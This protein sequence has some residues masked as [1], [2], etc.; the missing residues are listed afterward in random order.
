MTILLLSG[1]VFIILLWMIM[2]LNYDNGGFETDESLEQNRKPKIKITLFIG[3][4]SILYTIFCIIL[5]HFIL[6]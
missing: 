3:V 5:L 4:L 1:Y 6:N 2:M